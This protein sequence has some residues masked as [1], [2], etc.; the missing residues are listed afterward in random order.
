VTTGRRGGHSELLKPYVPRLVLDWLR[1]EPDAAHRQVEGSLAFVD[2]SGF[3]RLTE[4]LARKGKVGAEEMSD[5]LDSCFTDLLSVAYDYGAGLVKWGGDAV[6]LLF[7]G[8][9]H[10]PR[11][12]RAAAEMQR[13]IRRIG[14]LRASGTPVTLRM[15][16]GI[17][18]GAFD[19]FLVGDLHR[20]LIV[21]GPAATETVL[22]E[23]IAD[24]GQVALSPATA[25]LLDPSVLGSP[26][27]PAVLLRRPPDVAIDRAAPVERVDDLDL[28]V[29]LPPPI[30]EHLLSER[31]DS[32][33]RAIAV[34]FVELQGADELLG[35]EGAASLADALLGAIRTIHALS[36]KHI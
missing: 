6:L 20:E 23:S 19:F 13:E 1:H 21:T 33:H 9:E 15:S 10:A 27:E 29:F 35:R 18:S 36:L 8:E 5:T 26:K 3:T 2:I 22:M 25:S 31:G 12:C 11:A 4:R 32:E 24:A 7:T 14:R 34:A 17:H 16:V 30:R 28:G